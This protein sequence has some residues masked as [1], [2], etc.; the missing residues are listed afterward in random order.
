MDESVK[1]T[2]D[3]LGLLWMDQAFLFLSGGHVHLSWQA[4]S[5]V[6]LLW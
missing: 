2:L 4:G 5:L 1:K 6:K 3:P